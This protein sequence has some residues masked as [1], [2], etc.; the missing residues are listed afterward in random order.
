MKRRFFM[1]AMLLG[2][3]EIALPLGCA[4]NSNSPL[5]SEELA[6]PFM[7]Q[8]S[9]TE[10]TI[11]IQGLKKPLT[12]LQITDSH[13]S[14]LD[15]SEK[16]FHKYA[17]RMDNAYL[18]QPHFLTGEPTTAPEGFL[19][20]L[21]L[22]R[23]EKVDLLALTG[24][25]VNNPSKS[26]VRFVADA[27]D[28]A[29]VPYFFTAG[30]HDWCY[31]GLP[32]GPDDLRDEWIEEALLPLYSAGVDPLNYAVQMGGINF[33]TIDNSTYQVTA[34]Q[35]AFYRKEIARGL[36]TVLLIHIPIQI[37]GFDPGPGGSCGAPRTSGQLPLAST[38]EFVQCVRQSKNLVAALTGHYH[39]ALTFPMG[40]TG[41]QYVTPAACYGAYRLVRFLPLG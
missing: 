17:A 33:V 35:A 9:W 27:L 24:D 4:R 23:K 1:Q 31:E 30:N 2:A 38:T 13:I 8:P 21:D 26:S 19:G 10:T 18:S 39:K 16:A 12:V 6:T 14:V 3:A 32:G 34:S 22:A 11:R 41:T 40:P 29:G 20:V 25:I 37:S 28:Q 15:D 5:S 36:P 7:V